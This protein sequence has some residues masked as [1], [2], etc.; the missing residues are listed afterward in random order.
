MKKCNPTFLVVQSVFLF[1][2]IF[3]LVGCQSEYD[4][5]VDQEL[6]RNVKID[7]VF[8][9]LRLGESKEVYFKKC[10]DLNHDRIITQGR[11]YHLLKHNYT[12]TTEMDGK[13]DF[14]IEFQGVFNKDNK[15]KGLDAKFSHRLWSIWSQE[16]H[17]DKL[18][19]K[20]LDSLSKW[21]PGN[22]FTPFDLDSD[23]IPRV[24][25]KID[26]DRRFRVYPIDTRDVAVKI[27]DLNENN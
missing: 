12:D 16:Y 5:W 8:F 10:W 21:F 11:S 18:L 27:D 2:L 22:A 7:S 15:V 4:K 20:V 26:G 3:S 13:N 25:V 9:D 19:P 6:A 17:A 1:V 14:Y 23:S 24:Y